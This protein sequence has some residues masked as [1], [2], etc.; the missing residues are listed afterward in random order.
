LRIDLSKGT[1]IRSFLY[2]FCVPD[3]VEDDEDVQ[4]D[5][6]DVKHDAEAAAQD[7]EDA[8]LI[9]E[10]EEEDAREAAEAAEAAE[11]LAAE[12]L[13]SLGDE[14]MHGRADDGAAEPKPEEKAPVEDEDL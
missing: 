7:E 13:S 1:K 4:E 5:E 3:E 2:D 6:E 14:E 10:I 8:A 9:K 11:A 12:A